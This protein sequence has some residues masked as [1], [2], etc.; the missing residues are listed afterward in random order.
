MTVWAWY[1]WPLL[2]GAAGLLFGLLIGHALGVSEERKRCDS[3]TAAMM[4][5]RDAI[6]SRVGR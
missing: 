4:A 3:R 5:V 1:D 6:L 2:A